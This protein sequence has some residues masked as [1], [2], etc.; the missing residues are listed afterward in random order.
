MHNTCPAVFSDPFRCH[1]KEQYLEQLLALL[2]RGRAWQSHEALSSANVIHYDDASEC[3]MMECGEG[4]TGKVAL[5]VERTIM[6]AYWAA[7]AGIHEYFADRACQLLDEFFCQSLHETED[8]WG[9]DYGFPD[10]C[11]PWITLCEKVA[12]QGGQSCEYITWAAGRRGWAIECRDCARAAREPRAGCAQAGCAVICM[13]CIP[14]T[15]YVTI[16]LESSPAYTPTTRRS[17]P[18]AGR[19]EAGCTLLC[20]DI[21]QKEIECLIERIKPAHVVAVYNYV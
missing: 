14:S 16:D 21:D 12:A 11:W 18:F 2:P 4:T 1:T 8:W 13:D 17:P 19:A 6:T 20:D 7:N 5:R 15:I 10:P 3:G 9:T